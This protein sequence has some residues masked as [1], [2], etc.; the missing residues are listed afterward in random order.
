MLTFRNTWC[1]FALAL[2]ACAGMSAGFRAAQEADT[3]EAYS[4]FL[5][6]NPEGDEAERARERIAELQFEEAREADTI[7]A[8]EE[9]L[10][11]QRHGPAADSA[12]ARVV[13]LRFAQADSARSVEAL[14]EFIREHRD[15]PLAA[16]ARDRLEAVYEAELERAIAADSE[17]AYRRFLRLQPPEEQ[18]FKALVRLQDFERA[19]VRKI[20]TSFQSKDDSLLVIPT[21]TPKPDGERYSFTIAEGGSELGIDII[22]LRAELPDD[23]YPQ[24]K[25]GKI[26]F[27]HGTLGTPPGGVIDRGEGWARGTG[28]LKI[29]YP[30]GVTGRMPRQRLSVLGADEYGAM[31][32]GVGTVL[33]FVG[34][35]RFDN[36][37]FDGDRLDPLVFILL[38]ERGMV[39][40][41]GSGT[42]TGLGGTVRLPPTG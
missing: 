22:E 25:E 2:V 42:V 5:Q 32:L 30:L 24:R 14:R 21:I 6:E 13:E 8:Y 10:R 40:V 39:Y 37:A 36:Y 3:V 27:D 31:P 28:A 1:L 17:P 7:P 20:A 15:S 12:R 18:A 4:R 26:Y 9:F 11:F 41:K 38:N 29:N 19:A 16:K 33:R 35:V 23:S 34:R